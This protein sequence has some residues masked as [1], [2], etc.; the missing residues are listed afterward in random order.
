MSYFGN[1][2]GNVFGDVN[3]VSLSCPFGGSCNRTRLSAPQ[4][5]DFSSSTLYPS[6][7][8]FMPSNSFSTRGTCGPNGCGLKNNFY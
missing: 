4:F 7:L 3:G 1:E 5:N 2:F 8:P 6:Y